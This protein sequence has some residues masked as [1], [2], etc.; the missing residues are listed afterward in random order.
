MAEPLPTSLKG[1]F[2]LWDRTLVPQ[3][4]LC[5]LMF[6]LYTL[7]PVIIPFKI[8]WVVSFT[9]SIACSHLRSWSDVLGEASWSRS[10]LPQQCCYATFSTI[11]CGLSLI[12]A[13]A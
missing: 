1:F 2:E 12:L 3:I 10:A 6:W 5:V 8:L 7:H 4:L 13:R 11:I 9:I